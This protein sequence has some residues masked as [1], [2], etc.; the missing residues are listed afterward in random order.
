MVKVAYEKKVKNDMYVFLQEWPEGIDRLYALYR[1][2]WYP[3][4]FRDR[5]A[6]RVAVT[7][8]AFDEQ[9]AVVLPNLDRAVAIYYIRFFSEKNG[10]IKN[11]GQYSL[12]NFSKQKIYYKLNK[13][14]VGLFKWQVEIIFRGDTQEFEL[15]EIEI[16]QA[17]G[18]APAFKNVGKF[19]MGIHKM[20]VNGSYHVLCP[21]NVKK[22]NG[23]NIFLKDNELYQSYVFRADG[24]NLID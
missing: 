8:T 23:V 2:D 16:Y 1:S 7:R 19:V 13:K 10:R 21:G 12:E 3:N 5:E 17:E 14:R 6:Q 11:E 4:D 9:K 24:S 20:R 22:G 18:F 15:P